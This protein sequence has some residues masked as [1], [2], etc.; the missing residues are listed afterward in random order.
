VQQVLERP[1]R[2]AELR[3][4]GAGVEKGVGYDLSTYNNLTNYQRVHHVM[5]IDVN[6]MLYSN[7]CDYCWTI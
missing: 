5:L 3:E 7:I 6:G 4:V 2:L 1:P